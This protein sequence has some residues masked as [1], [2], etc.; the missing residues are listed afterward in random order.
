MLRSPARK[1]GCRPQPT[2]ERRFDGT[3]PAKLLVSP[4]LSP[5]EPASLVATEPASLATEPAFLAATEPASL[6]AI[7]RALP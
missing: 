5:I 6:V 1:S 2:G 4:L 3:H 7:K